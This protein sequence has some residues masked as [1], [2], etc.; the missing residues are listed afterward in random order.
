MSSTK[1]F[2]PSLGSFKTLILYSLIRRS[3]LARY[4]SLNNKYRHIQFNDLHSVYWSI[5]ILDQYSHIV[6]QF[7]IFQI[8]LYL[9][10]LVTTVHV[11]LYGQN[12]NIIRTYKLASCF[13]QRH[14]KI[15]PK[16]FRQIKLCMWQAWRVKTKYKHFVAKGLFNFTRKHNRGVPFIWN[17]NN[18][19]C[20]AHVA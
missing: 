17:V 13:F 8:D 2:F 1:S 16:Y 18:A 11:L 7:N 14:Q 4:S 10:R 20:D 19:S 3:I 9:S 12:Y 5:N 15:I 6:Y